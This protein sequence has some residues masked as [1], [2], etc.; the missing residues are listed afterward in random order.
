MGAKALTCSY[1]IEFNGT[2]VFELLVFF[3]TFP[4]CFYIPIIFSNS[5]LNCSNVLDPE[6][7]KKKVSILFQASK[8]KSFMHYV[9]EQFFL[10]LGQNNFENKIHIIE[11]KYFSRRLFIH[12]HKYYQVHQCNFFSSKLAFDLSISIKIPH[13][14]SCLYMIWF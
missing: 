9:I 12:K 11:L 13:G 4:A 6:K 3:L 7:V 5:N 1:P 10:R 2:Q 8:F 14:W